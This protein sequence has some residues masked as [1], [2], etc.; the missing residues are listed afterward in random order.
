M[1]LLPCYARSP[2]GRR[3]R[4]RSLDV[5]ALVGFRFA[6]TMEERSN[7]E[8][9]RALPFRTSSLWRSNF[10]CEG[11]WNALAERFMVAAAGSRERLAAALAGQANRL[12]AG[13][14]EVPP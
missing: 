9:A 11:C 6:R 10:V 12:S 4:S 3:R 14:Q 13:C 2:E 8:R 7:Y 1:T 5:G